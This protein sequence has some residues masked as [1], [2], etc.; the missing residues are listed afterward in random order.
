M[1]KWEKDGFPR[2]ALPDGFVF[3][4]SGE[5][6]EWKEG[7]PLVE[8]LGITGLQEGGGSIQGWLVC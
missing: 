4:G 8:E 2:I 3:P 6:H 5:L 1:Y 7:M